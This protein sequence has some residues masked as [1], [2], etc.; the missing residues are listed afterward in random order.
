MAGRKKSSDQGDECPPRFFLWI[1][2]VFRPLGEGFSLV[3]DLNEE[4]I[5]KVKT[6]GRSHARWWYRWETARSIP[7]LCFNLFLWGAVMIQNYFKIAWRILYRNKVFS[8]IN[9]TGL[10]VGMACTL[11]IGLYLHHELNFDRFH[12]DGSRIY[13]V[14]AHIINGGET[15]RGAWTSPPLAEALKESFPEIES[16]VRFSP[17]SATFL[18]RAGRKQ[19][20]E[21]D[22][23]FA[24][25]A[26]FDIFDF[27]FIA[28]DPK[29]ALRD[30]LTVVITARGKS[31]YGGIPFD[32]HAC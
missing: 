30:P 2:E 10:A 14:C 13:R 5:N 32:D 12:K 8:I 1:L 18:I 3:G 25:A 7:E 26:F 27:T 28:G 19:F 11:I 20:L 22:I 15:F 31:S 9:L 23:R 24:D 17:W 29:T 6:E 16:A 21:D 4:Y